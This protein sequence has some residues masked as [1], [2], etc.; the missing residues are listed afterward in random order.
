MLI[1]SDYI[2]TVQHVFSVATEGPTWKAM[3]III[4]QIGI[5]IQIL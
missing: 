3:E 2:P 5:R 4:S 1:I